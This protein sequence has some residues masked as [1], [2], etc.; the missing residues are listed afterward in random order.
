MIHRF[1]DVANTHP[2]D[3]AIGGN[4]GKKTTYSELMNLSS[5]IAAAITLSGASASR[6]ALLQE[7][8]PRWVASIIAVMMTGGVYLPL[9][10][11]VPRVRLAAIVKDC[12]PSLILVDDS[13]KTQL[14]DLQQP[15]LSVINVSV[16]EPKETIS[17][18][19]ATTHGE[20]MILYTSGSS[21]TPKGIMLQ[22]EGIR[23]QI[24]VTEEV[25]GINTEV[26]L[27]QSASSFDLSYSQIFTALCFGGSL[28][29]LPRHLR[30]DAYIIT[31]I[32]SSEN[33]TYTSATPTEYSSWLRYGEATSLQHSSWR[34]ALCAG[35][36]VPM[37]LLQ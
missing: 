34:T 27:Q 14:R 24:E 10:L 25:Y 3:I 29:L 18:V 22:H 21:G 11:S 33:I 4:T 2:N 23:N 6:I 20:A 8:S 1:Q 5:S 31:E 15:A 13:S 12:N 26:V 17:L 7:P 36:A 16:L 28:Y 30:G 35:E 37:S 9:D 32:I 19:K